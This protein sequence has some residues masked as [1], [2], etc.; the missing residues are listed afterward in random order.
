METSSITSTDSFRD[1]VNRSRYAASFQRSQSSTDA[2]SV[3]PTHRLLAR[4]GLA[5]PL[6]RMI[7]YTEDYF[8]LDAVSLVSLPIRT[9]TGQHSTITADAGGDSGPDQH[10]MINVSLELP[11]DA[12]SRFIRFIRSFNLGIVEVC[13]STLQVVKPSW[14]AKDGPSI[15]ADQLVSRQGEPAIKKEQVKVTKEIKPGWKLYTSCWD[16]W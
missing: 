14:K 9:S 6:T 12:D 13:H 1:W 11:L 7:T 16:N 2:K 5:H 15:P 8:D 4:F 10:A 3:K